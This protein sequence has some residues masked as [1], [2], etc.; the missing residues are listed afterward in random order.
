MAK[1]KLTIKLTELKSLTSRKKIV[2]VTIQG[3]PA[4]VNEFLNILEEKRLLKDFV[5]LDK[6]MEK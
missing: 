2:E 4:A 5:I 3:I 1:Y 6:L